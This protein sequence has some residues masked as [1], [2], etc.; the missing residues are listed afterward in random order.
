MSAMSW[1]SLVGSFF[2]AVTALGSTKGLVS[3]GF[4]ECDQIV[5]S[6]GLDDE[7]KVHGRPW[8]AIADQG[9]AADYG[10]PV[11]FFIEKGGYDAKDGSE[12]QRTTSPSVGAPKGPRHIAGDFS[13]R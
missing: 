9:D 3:A 2:I 8:K 1:N 11:A 7:I 10:V 5:L 6:G 13:P 12:V 4:Q